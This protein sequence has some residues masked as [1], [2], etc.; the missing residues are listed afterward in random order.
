MEVITFFVISYT[1]L[2]NQCFCHILPHFCCNLFE[3][4]QVIDVMDTIIV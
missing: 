2:K 4:Y 1:V 3:N